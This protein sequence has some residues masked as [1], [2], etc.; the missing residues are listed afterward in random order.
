MSNYTF[1]STPYHGKVY[2]DHQEYITELLMPELG[3]MHD[4]YDL[5]AIAADMLVRIGEGW[6]EDARNDWVKIVVSHQVAPFFPE[7]DTP[8][9]GSRRTT[10]L[11]KK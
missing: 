7:M 8:P 6:V 9:L 3:W 5:K 10:D 4:Q 2:R 11:H 1:T